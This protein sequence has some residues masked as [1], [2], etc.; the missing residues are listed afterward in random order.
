[1][2]DP[3]DMFGDKVEVRLRMEM[4]RNFAFLDAQQNSF[5]VNGMLTRDDHIG[6]HLVWVDITYLDPKDQPQSFSNSFIL[7]VLP[8][9][10]IEVPEIFENTQLE[11]ISDFNGRVVYEPQP[12][13]DLERPIPYVVDLTQTG[14]LTIG[15]NR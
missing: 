5:K 11:V 15:W 7:T 9:K 12:D 8:K 14:L 13:I 2:G 4:A 10:V 6:N 1:M 3:I